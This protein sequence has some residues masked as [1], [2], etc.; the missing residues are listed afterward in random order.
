M[1]SL[2]HKFA[3]DMAA[4]DSQIASFDRAYEKNAA[5]GWK[6]KTYR[7]IPSGD[8]FMLQEHVAKMN[9]VPDWKDEQF[10]RDRVWLD[11]VMAQRTK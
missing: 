5:N 9:G 1:T 6:P 11:K 8:G 2:G 3:K 4:I 7:I 10:S